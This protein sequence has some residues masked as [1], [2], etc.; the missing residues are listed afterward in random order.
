[1]SRREARR[2]CHVLSMLQC[3]AVFWAS[4]SILLSYTMGQLVLSAVFSTLLRIVSY[5]FLQVIP[6]RLAV[7]ALPLLYI[8]YLTSLRQGRLDTDGVKPEPVGKDEKK[9]LPPLPKVFILHS[10]QKSLAY[11]G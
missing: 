1:M 4:A 2:G 8:G 3:G 6:T 5:I 9:P 11:T 10:I 7:P